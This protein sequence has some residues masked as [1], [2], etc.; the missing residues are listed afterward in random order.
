M[1]DVRIVAA[2]NRDP[3]EAVELGRLRADLYYRL[4][5]MVLRVP[6]LR[7]RVEDIAPLASSIL[8]RVRRT[9]RH[10]PTSFDASAL[11]ALEEYHWPGNVRELRNSIERVAILVDA[12]VA[13]R[14]DL[15]ACGI[16][17][18]PRETPRVEASPRSASSDSGSRPRVDDGE[19]SL[20]KVAREA[21]DQAE[22]RRILAVLDETGG[23]RTRA[24]EILQVSRSTLWSKLRRYGIDAE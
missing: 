8:A 7:E 9:T 14:E 13:T 3:K 23:N 2:T 11:R 18:A 16:F 22:R 17:D 24:A 12:P 21:A 5:T 4:A 20:E 15:E 19:R 1:S 10:G 6:P